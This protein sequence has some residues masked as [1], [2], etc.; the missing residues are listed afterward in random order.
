M[1]SLRTWRQAVDGLRTDLRAALAARLRALVVYEAHG[2]LGEASGPGDGDL[3][4]N[5][6]VHTLVV[7]DNLDYSDLARLAPLAANWMK[8]GLA[9]PLFLAPEELGRS[10]DAFPLEFS[11]MIARHVV[12]EGDD[13]L[14]GLA[15]ADADLRRACEEQVRSHLLHLREGY[16]Q[17]AG[18]PEAL[19]GLVSAS[20]LPFRALLVNVARL[21]GANAR[22]PEALARFAEEQLHLRSDGVR[23]LL[24]AKRSEQ[25]RDLDVGAFFPAYLQAVEQLTLLVDTWTR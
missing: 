13:P 11:Q 25:V 16:I 10:L 23:P 2:M 18:K 4:H 15:V 1:A 19:A 24:L 7:V 5:D 12:I 3:Q 20:V 14:A 8:N 21:H 22:T 17:S 9:V 6:H